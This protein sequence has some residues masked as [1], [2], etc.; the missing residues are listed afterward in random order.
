MDALTDHL[1]DILNQAKI[2]KRELDQHRDRYA[3]FGP[4]HQSMIEAIGHLEDALDALD[5][6]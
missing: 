2:I 1:A 5:D 6:A 3:A 4:A